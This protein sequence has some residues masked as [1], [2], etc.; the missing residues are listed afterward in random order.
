VLDLPSAG[1]S[2]RRGSASILVNLIITP[3]QHGQGICSQDSSSS[4]DRSIAFN[5]ADLSILWYVS[6]PV[7]I[8]DWR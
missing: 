6:M 5:Q 1:S 3:G 7:L 8:G 4:D 2:N